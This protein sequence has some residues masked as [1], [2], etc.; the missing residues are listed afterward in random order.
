MVAVFIA[1]IENEQ[2]FYHT[3]VKNSVS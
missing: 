1:I 2:S 3:S